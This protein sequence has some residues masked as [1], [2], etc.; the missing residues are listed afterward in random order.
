MGVDMDSSQRVRESVASTPYEWPLDGEFVVARSALVMI[1]WQND[2]C[3]TGG[4]VDRMG[5]D[6]QRLRRCVE[7]ASEVLR[8]ARRVGLT[9]IHT[10]EGHRSDLSD[11]TLIKL[12]KSRR[13]GC[14]IGEDAG[15]GRVLVRGEPGWEIIPELAPVD[16]EVVIDKPGKGSFYATDLEVILRVLGIS[17]LVLTGVTT[18]VCVHTTMREASDRGIDCLLLSDCTGTVDGENYSAALKMITMSGGVFGA[19]SGSA[20]FLKALRE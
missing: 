11:L 5:Y 18:D 4:Y 9:V 14:C 7:P 19:V 10:R 13:M 2:F 17:H 16:G 1:D 8:A 6:I 12:L 20:A 3:S 15:Y